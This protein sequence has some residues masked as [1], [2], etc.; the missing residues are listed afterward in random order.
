MTEKLRKRVFVMDQLAAGQ[1]TNA[2]AAKMLGLSVRQ[3]KRIK[4]EMQSNGIQA[5][6]HGNAGR[7]PLSRH[8]S[9]S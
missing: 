9:S 4:K 8:A 1:I 7:K 6:G 3:I 5:L 2:Q